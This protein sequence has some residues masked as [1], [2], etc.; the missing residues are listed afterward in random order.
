[1]TR[2]VVSIPAYDEE[3]TIGDVIREV[4][5]DL[6]GVDE[7]LV[8][9]VDDG[10]SDGRAEA[11]R[12]A[13]VD[14]VVR[15]K[16]NR[17]L[18]CAFARGLNEALAMGADII[19]NTDADGQYV[20]AEIPDLIAPILADE[21]DLVLGSRFAG[22]IEAMPF[23]KRVGNRIATWVTRL[24]SGFATTD[25]QTGFRAFTRDAALRLNVLSHYTYTQ[26]TIIQAV[27]KDLVV[28][29]VPVTFRRRRGDG[30][31]RLIAN[32]LS[33]A[34]NAG[35]IIIRTSRDYR[36]L[37]PFLYLGGTLFLAGFAM[38]MRVLVHF[39]TTGYVSPYIPSAILSTLLSIIGFQ[40]IMLG[41]VADMLA[42]NRVLEERIL[43]LM[44]N[45]C[46]PKVREGGAT[47][48]RER[49]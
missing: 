18:A 2:L 12:A 14:S 33:Y 13:G 9:V 3:D 1:M 16:R 11:A 46:L 48:G 44:K 45:E 38:G 30:R 28:V 22:T 32:V 47:H 6:E 5:R 25:A 23:Q 26:E 41:M 43:Y 17:G 8:L 35:A 49:T 20:G 24:V 7:V 42:A 21:A 31:S 4:P 36:P 10:S 27:H 19:V 39:V 40:V 29:E 15:F 34:K 37:K